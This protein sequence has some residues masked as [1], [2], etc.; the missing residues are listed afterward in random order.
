MGGVF[1]LSDLLR[2]EEQDESPAFRLSDLLDP[3][4]PLEEIGEDARARRQRMEGVTLPPPPRPRIP[5]P[6]AAEA[7]QQVDVQ[8]GPSFGGGFRDAMLSLKETAGET[9]RMAGRNLLPEPPSGYPRPFGMTTPRDVVTRAGRSMATEAR[10]QAAATPKPKPL[11][12]V[13]FSNVDEIADWAAYTAGQGVGSSV[14]SLIGAAVGSAAGPAGALAGAAIPSYL[15]NQNEVRQA[16][17]QEGLDE[18]TADRIS[19]VAAAPMAALDALMPGRIG[20]KLT[21]PARAAVM[22]GIARRLLRGTAEGVLLEGTTEGIQEGVSIAT[23]AAATGRPVGSE[24]VARRGEMIEAGAGGA[25]TGGLLSGV[26]QAVTE[27]RSV[28]PRPHA[29]IED[30]LGGSP[31]SPSAVASPPL[32]PRPRARPEPQPPPADP[33]PPAPSAAAAAAVPTPGPRPE[34]PPEVVPPF[35][36][37]TGV[38]VPAAEPTL[39]PE[40]AAERAGIDREREELERTD[41]EKQ[42]R[43]PYTAP[44]GIV[45]MNREDLTLDPERMQWRQDFAEG[46]GTGRLKD[47]ETWNQDLADPLAVWQ[48]PADGRWIVVD[49]YNRMQAYDRLQP[50]VP[51][52]VRVIDAPDAL[53]ARA[54][55]AMLNIGRGHAERLDVARV[56]REMETTPEEIS[57]MGIPLR[58]G[59]ARDGLALSNLAPDVFERV[60]VGKVSEEVGVGVGEVLDTPEMQRTAI[61]LIEKS[62]KRLTTPEARQLALQV[63][64]AGTETVTQET[65]FGTE[66]AGVSLMVPKAQLATAWT[67]RA[68]ADK[69]FARVARQAE[70]LSRGGNVINV[71]G[72]ERIAQE[73]AQVE[74]ILGRMYT[75]S[76]PIAELLTEGARRIARGEKVAAVAGELYPRLAEAVSAEISGEGAGV[77][78]GVPGSSGLEGSRAPGAEGTP[79]QAEGAEPPPPVAPRTTGSVIGRIEPAPVGRPPVA[80]DL[81][82]IKGDA[83]ELVYRGDVDATNPYQP[84][85]PQHGWWEAQRRR[86]LEVD[87]RH[88]E[89][90]IESKGGRVTEQGEI[91]MPRRDVLRLEP[92]S[93]GRAEPI[94][95]LTLQQ[96][97]RDLKAEGIPIRTEGI[98][99]VPL[100]LPSD[101]GINLRLLP[102]E[103]LEELRQAL[104][105]DAKAG[106]LSPEHQADFM[107]LGAEQMQ[108]DYRA[109]HPGTPGPVQSGGEPQPPYRIEDLLG[110]PTA[111]QEPI[112]GP[113]A[114]SAPVPLAEP[115]IAPSEAPGK[116]PVASGA[117]GPS[118]TTESSGKAVKGRV[119]RADIEA[120]TDLALRRAA[121]ESRRLYVY[122]TTNGYAIETQRPPASQYRIVEPGGRVKERIPASRESPE[123]GERVVREKA[124]A[125]SD[126]PKKVGKVRTTNPLDV[127]NA[128][129]DAYNRAH[130]RVWDVLR[131][132]AKGQDATMVGV[133]IINGLQGGVSPREAIEGAGASAT[134]EL[135]EAVTHAQRLHY[136]VEKA[137]LAAGILP[138]EEVKAIREALIAKG[139]PP[140]DLPTRDGELATFAARAGLPGYTSDEATFAAT[141]SLNL[142]NLVERLRGL[143]EELTQATAIG[144]QT[145]MATARARI[146]EIMPSIPESHPVRHMVQDAMTAADE[147]LGLRKKGTQPPTSKK[148]APVTPQIAAP[149]GSTPMGMKPTMPEPL[150]DASQPAL[151]GPEAMGPEPEPGQEGFFSEREG[152][153]AARNLK[154]TEA[155]ARTELESLRERLRLEKDPERRAVIARQIAEREKLVNRGKAISAEEMATRAAGEET[156][157]AGPDETL[158]LLDA[159]A[160]RAVRG[161]ADAGKAIEGARLRKVL[162]R[163]DLTA[164]RR[165]E[166]E[167]R[168]DELAEPAKSDAPEPVDDVADTESDDQAALFSPAVPKSFRDR[169]R[170]LKSDAVKVGDEERVRSLMQIGKNLAEAVSV[171]LRQGRFDAARRQ[172]EG[173][174]KPHAEVAR[175]V[176]FDALDKV[177]HEVGHYVSKHY[178]RNPA[179]KVS[180]G[181]RPP[182]SAMKELVQMGRDLYGSR[183]PNAGYGEEGIAEWVSFYVTDHTALAQKAPTFT[184]WMDGVL[185]QEPI[186]KAA[187]DQAKDDFTRYVAAPPNA[188]VA[189]MLSVNERARNR[190]TVRVLMRTFLDD[191]YE[192]RVA[193]RELGGSSLPSKDAYVLARLTRG[194]AG[195]AEEMLERGVTRYQTNERAAPSVAKALRQVGP[196]RI[197]AFREY[198]VAESALERIENGIDPGIAREDA[199]AIIKADQ[200]KFLKYAQVLWDHGNALL[201]MRRDAGLLTPEE[202]ETIKAKNTRRV[203]FYRVFEPEESA[204][205]KGTGKAFAR[206]ASGVKGQKGSARQILDVLEGVVKDTYDTVAQVRKYEVARELVRLS[207]TTEGGGRI[208]EK[209]PAPQQAVRIS[210]EKLEAQL[211]ELGLVYEGIDEKT[212]K[213]FT[214]KIGGP[215]GFQLEGVLTAFQDA[216]VGGPAESKDLVIPLLE[217]GE[218]NWYAVR[219]R[220]LYE[221]ALGLGTPE[222]STVMRWISGPARTLRTGATLTPEFIGR[223]PVRDAW[224]SAVFSKAATRPPLYR[225]S[226]GLFHALKADE[227]Y[228]RWKLEGGDN[229]AMLGLDRPAVQKDLKR[230]MTPHSVKGAVVTVVKH[231]IDTLRMLSSLMENGSRLGEFAAR[232]RELV[233]EGKDPREA[234][235][236]AAL[237]ARD[238]SLDFAQDGTVG[239]SANQILAFLNAWKRGQA[240]MMR[241]MKERPG[242][243]L[244]RGALWITLPSILLY[245]MQKDDPAYEKVPNWKRNVGWVILDRGD[246]QGEGWDG[247]GSGKVEHEWVIPK[248]FELGV[249]FGTVPERIVEYIDKHNPESLR[250][251]RTEVLKAFTPPHVPTAIAPLIENYA[252]RSLFRDRPIVPRGRVDLDPAEQVTPRTGETARVVGG[253]VGYSPAKIENAVR[254]YTGGLGA[255][256]LAGSDAVVRGAREALGKPP[257]R[258]DNTRSGDDALTRAPFIRGF[259]TRPTG[260]DAEPIER[261][262]R[263]FGEADQHRRTWKAMI[264]EGRTAEAASYFTEHREAIASVAIDDDNLPSGV[265]ALRSAYNRMQDLNRQA[266]ATG[267]DARRAEQISREKQDLAAIGRYVAPPPPVARPVRPRRP[268]RPAQPVRP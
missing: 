220:N 239:R 163:D 97:K 210:A 249:L 42:G 140:E 248:P 125:E 88:H 8:P 122:P 98:R 73:S 255:Y 168:L 230:L 115:S 11:A 82:Y 4:N 197:Q 170:A 208:I 23:R 87:D 109:K 206:N 55:G 241:E 182:R 137:K 121:T 26:T 186:L 214:A 216:R 180:A 242:T 162:E 1:R 190:P 141:P 229:A 256:G 22:K 83:P 20:S 205:G 71:E 69:V 14:P 179:R 136:G 151:F 191:L 195:A 264:R 204:S 259:A 246:D 79:Q 138:Y 262:Y 33:R 12:E 7:T 247:Y 78:S 226:E 50:G 211:N 184:T 124:S 148:R 218:R 68:G 159:P 9:I 102:D 44:R 156:P 260:D 37:G 104:L 56:L 253:V 67:R 48:D 103:G 166:I 217:N 72:S 261:L 250:A 119:N 237:D 155:S 36:R 106:G 236:Q 213:P 60:A 263:D 95:D 51:L 147:A 131:F 194:A 70:Q 266:R 233:K 86:S 2:E 58:S 40:A 61:A 96:I 245:L 27:G 112:S 199:L 254:G 31:P 192:F 189:A 105:Q 81:D 209:V 117:S 28:A 193:V 116:P 99:E 94:D 252:N 187:L 188:R 219:D 133:Q 228:Q 150:A 21:G 29:A 161:A 167:A 142:P 158:P 240:Q 144:K 93:E 196:K 30:F 173:A 17:L 120:M 129:I 223:N 257:M 18:D 227:V 134:P 59:V 62:G 177:A 80:R 198:L 24:L 3:S 172:A 181:A 212:G 251:L 90:V 185:E 118:V 46:G 128:G 34:V 178:L 38:Q 146:R 202:T 64:A 6:M 135:L 10:E 171:P 152:T 5:K 267:V 244:L 91:A 154:Q 207:R 39:S 15:Q 53:A 169:L 215:G 203:P 130:E 35:M 108:R 160:D 123:G 92:P 113:P 57:A 243:I 238:V 89:T 224:S 174:F 183:T 63:R 77:S 45:S 268:T 157:G 175:V 231:P 164:A 200:P 101:P 149:A 25:L 132:Q 13:D 114:A 19:A 41:P 201:D 111:A 222:L 43:A 143:V 225:L 258:P 49:G 16:L 235:V 232:E 100:A 52:D 84:E 66:E 110:E 153:A 176:R 165:S 74:E 139:Y 32:P 265:G 221:A 145:M 126:A 65:L 76:G 75:R 127:V 47:V 54:K 107:A 85:T 234:S